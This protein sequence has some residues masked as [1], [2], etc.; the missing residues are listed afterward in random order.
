MIDPDVLTIVFLLVLV[1]AALLVPPGPGT[2]LR[3][4]VGSR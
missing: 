1:I 3:Q 4:S 2:P